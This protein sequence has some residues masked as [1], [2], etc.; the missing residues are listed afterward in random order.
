MCYYSLFIYTHT[1]IKLFLKIRKVT[2]SWAWPRF[3][4]PWLY[5][6]LAAPS[7]PRLL[8]PQPRLQFKSPC[9]SKLKTAVGQIKKAPLD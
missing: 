4:I 5:P 9:I 8:S 7:L 1:C 3:M 6:H 2:K